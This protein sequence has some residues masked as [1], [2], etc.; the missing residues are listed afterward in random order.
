MEE[1]DKGEML[2]LQR[3]L[4]GPKKRKNNM[5]V[6]FTLVVLSKAKFAH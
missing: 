2:V 1:A 4:S 5:R 3:A 6:S